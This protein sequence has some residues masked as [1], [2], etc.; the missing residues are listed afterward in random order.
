MLDCP[1]HPFSLPG[2][3][4]SAG[5]L[6]RSALAALAFSRWRMVVS[7]RCVETMARRTICTG[8]PE[9]G[10]LDDDE[11]ALPQKVIG[12]NVEDVEAPK[13]PEDARLGLK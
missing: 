3:R 11:I 2:Y 5:V 7:L 1:V 4:P 13:E 12:V 8:A 10:F 9:P 6:E